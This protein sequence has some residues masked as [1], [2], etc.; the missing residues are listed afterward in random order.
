MPTDRPC[1]FCIGRLL[2]GVQCTQ[3]LIC[4]ARHTHAVMSEPEEV[5][6]NEEVAPAVAQEM[7]Q[8]Q[9]VAPVSQ[10]EEE[11]QPNAPEEE[12]Q[13]TPTSPDESKYEDAPAN[14]EVESVAVDVAAAAADAPVA[15]PAPEEEATPA[16]P[17]V[18]VP[19]GPDPS[20][21]FLPL[22]LH[23]IN[24]TYVAKLNHFLQSDPIV[25]VAV[26]NRPMMK[27]TIRPNSTDSTWDLSNPEDVQAVPGGIALP[28][29][30]SFPTI[31]LPVSELS[32]SRLQVHQEDFSRLKCS[33]EMG[34]F[35]IPLEEIVTR[36]WKKDVKKAGVPAT[37]RGRAPSADQAI[38]SPTPAAPLEDGWYPVSI[39]NASLLDRVTGRHL[40]DVSLTLSVRL[41]DY[42]QY[43]VAS[44]TGLHL[45]YELT[46]Q[47]LARPTADTPL[48]HV[49]LDP[50]S[51]KALIAFVVKAG[52]DKGSMD[53]ER[54]R[55]RIFSLIGKALDVFKPDN[56][57][58]RAHPT[59]TYAR[60]CHGRLIAR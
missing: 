8:Q 37:P 24:T 18:V 9:E 16:V 54:M 36:S 23:T 17:A 2:A 42:L 7:E 14:A 32:T 55:E 19:L 50:A 40:G 45:I 53:G 1:I 43:L 6:P 38:V 12:T 41:D 33:D 21:V 31:L 11:T 30:A 34:G 51:L 35:T 60:P 29:A 20:T 58:V 15:T 56:Q 22:Q 44:Q 52:A 59:R 27:T 10:E 39:D 3:R 48:R 28:P 4:T 5:Q 26:D 46:Q 47:F 57:I 49:L 13:P 25:V